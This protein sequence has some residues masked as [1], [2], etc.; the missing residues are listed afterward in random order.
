MFPNP[1]NKSVLTSYNCACVYY[2]IWNS[3]FTYSN[4]HFF[5]MSKSFL[6]IILARQNKRSRNIRK[7]VRALAYPGHPTGIRRATS[8]GLT[9]HKKWS[10]AFFQKILFICY[11]EHIYMRLEVNSIWLRGKI[12]L[13]CKVTSLSVFTWVQTKWNSIWCKFHLGQFDWTEISNRSEWFY[14]QLKE[15]FIG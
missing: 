2:G 15:E 1:R 10:F 3:F 13:R 12:S 14:S 6:I 11:L 9:L 5:F 4:V 8:P 7:R